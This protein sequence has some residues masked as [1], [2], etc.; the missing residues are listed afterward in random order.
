MKKMYVLVLDVETTGDVESNPLVYDVGAKIVDLAGNVYERGSWVIYD[1][2][3]QRDFMSSA[4]YAAKLPQY[5]RDLA[6]GSR[7]M[8]RFET[9]RKI[10]WR[11]MYKYDAFL[12]AAYNTSFDRRALNNT[13]RNLTGIKQCLFFPRKTKFIDIWRM[14]CDSICRTRDYH[15]MAYENGWYSDAGNV[16][17]N[18]ETVYGY[19]SN[20][21]NFK[22]SHTAL[23]DVDIETEIML[24]CWKKVK[25]ENRGIIGFP[26]R[27]PQKEWAFHEAKFDKII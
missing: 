26:W 8:A 7:K 18:A 22:E 10:I 17:T 23:E 24:Y 15:R 20:S 3:T 19:L 5:E 1:I 2:Y 6:N 14:A 12:V 27:I 21:P 25:A 11:W 4:Y 16:R 13:I 9:V